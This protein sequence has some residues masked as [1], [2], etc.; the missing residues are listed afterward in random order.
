MTVEALRLPASPG[1]ASL[2]LLRDAILA[3]GFGLGGI[4]GWRRFA[5]DRT[6]AG[7]S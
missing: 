7:E 6:A 2:R 1:H 4:A 5:A 3:L